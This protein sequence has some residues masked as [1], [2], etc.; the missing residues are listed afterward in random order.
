MFVQVISLLCRALPACK[1][2]VGTEMPT[3]LL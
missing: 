3:H 2:P 1:P